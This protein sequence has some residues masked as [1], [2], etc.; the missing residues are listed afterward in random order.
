MPNTPQ[1]IALASELRL[2]VTRLIKKLRAKSSL[3]G[4]LSLTERSTIALLDLHKELLPSELAAMEKVTTQSMSQILAHL[5]EL[6][7]IHRK[8]SETDKRKA[9]ITLSKTGAEVLNEVRNKRDEWLINA[10][11][12]TCTPEEQEVLRKVIAPLTKL[13]DY[14]Q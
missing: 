10:I 9:I 13:V 1:N 8:P 14:E 2:V 3:S 11:K 4:H 7:Y 12:Q 6:G 5:L